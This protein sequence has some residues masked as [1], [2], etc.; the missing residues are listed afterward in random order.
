LRQT[1]LNGAL[2]RILDPDSAVKAKAWRVKR[3]K[4][5][6]LDFSKELK[7]PGSIFPVLC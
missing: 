6:R 2:I 7:G 4:G 1:F 3:V 5:A